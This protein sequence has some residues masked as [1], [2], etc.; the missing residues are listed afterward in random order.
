MKPN[1]YLFGLFLTF[2]V[3]SCGSTNKTANN[4]ND[5]DITV[6]KHESNRVNNLDRSISLADHFRKLPGVMVKGSN[7]DAV[8]YVRGG[9]NS[10]TQN[11]EPLYIVNGSQFSGNFQLLSSAIDVSLIKSITVLKDASDTAFYG[12]RGANGVILIKLK[13]KI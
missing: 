9:A 4:G 5:I 3:V 7:E 10:F 13:E 1:T 6:T 8:V 11:A 12:M 2:I